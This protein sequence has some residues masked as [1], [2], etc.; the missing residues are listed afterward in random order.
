MTRH[1][2]Q[3]PGCSM[4]L[5]GKAVFCVPMLFVLVAV[6][7]QAQQTAV[8]VHGGI[9]DATLAEVWAAWNTTEG[10]KS[11]L[12]PHAEID[13]RIGGLMR[14]NYNPEGLLGDEQTIENIVLSYEPM[15]M[16][17]IKVKKTPA[18][19]PFPNA[20]QNMWTNM[21]FEP[22]GPDQTHIRIVGLGFESNEESQRMRAFFD[23]GNAIT[24]KQLQTHFAAAPD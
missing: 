6:P 24:L 2:G 10:L 4:K 14:T 8:I 7:L 1:P 17:S 20:I 12:A 11:W 9:V 13:L 5:F 21:Y 23:E 19:F 15:G 3:E 18:G 22:A 16:L